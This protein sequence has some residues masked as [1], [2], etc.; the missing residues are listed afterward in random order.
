MK[1]KAP[2][3]DLDHQNGDT[4]SAPHETDT[5][6]PTPNPPKSVAQYDSAKQARVTPTRSQ[7]SS[8]APPKT[9]IIERS[10]LAPTIPENAP[11]WFY[12]ELKQAPLSTPEKIIFPYDLN[13]GD[14]PTEPFTDNY[15]SEKLTVKDI[16]TVFDEIRTINN[17]NI[18]DIN[19]NKLNHI[20]YGL[21]WLAVLVKLGFLG[22]GFFYAVIHHN[23]WIFFG[24]MLYIIAMMIVP[25]CFKRWG[26]RLRQWLQFKYRTKKAVGI[27]EKWNQHFEW[28]SARW[29][30]G[31]PYA[32]WF[33]LETDIP[34]RVSTICTESLKTP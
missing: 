30:V 20:Y 23:W 14:Y 10:F 22:Y 27:L 21:V 1:P 11:H 18:E 24:L 5:L 3:E 31:G 16:E 9:P 33:E 6:I 8:S 4:H 26:I 12:E 2:I 25:L 13:Q 29:T 34:V 19:D 28:H 7:K 15:T 32:S 17:F